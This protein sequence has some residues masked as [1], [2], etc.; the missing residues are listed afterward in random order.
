VSDQ[1]DFRI[2]EVWKT[3]NRRCVVRKEEVY[4]RGGIFQKERGEV[5]IGGG[6][7]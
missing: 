2:R 5:K 4:K 7:V 1:R 3:P 6:L